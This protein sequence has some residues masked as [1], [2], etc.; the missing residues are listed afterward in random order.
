[1]AFRKGGYPKRNPISE[2]NILNPT[3]LGIENWGL[4]NPASLAPMKPK[5]LASEDTLEVGGTT[6]GWPQRLLG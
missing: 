2:P 4:R 3:P 6:H 1:M 5:T